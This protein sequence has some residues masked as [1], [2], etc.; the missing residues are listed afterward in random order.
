MFNAT[1]NNISVLSW[2]LP[3]YH[4]N[5]I[6]LQQITEIT[7]VGNQITIVGNQITIVGNQ[8]LCFYSDS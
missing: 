1:F 8:I 7:I 3:D 2:W 4:G 6:D 5:A